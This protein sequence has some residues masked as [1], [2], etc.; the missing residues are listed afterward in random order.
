MAAI[1]GLVLP[2]G[3]ARL[4]VPAATVAEVAPEPAALKPL[5]ASE[6]WVAGYFHWRNYP[7][8]LISFE[9][10][11]ANL[12][13][14]GYSRVCVFHPLP[15]RQPHDYFALIVNGEPRTLEITD[16][17]TAAP[18]P[19][20]LSRRFVAG[21]IQVE[22]QT[23]VIPDFDALQAAFYPQGRQRAGSVPVQ[24]E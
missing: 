7:V 13:M 8:T 10:I 2:T 14:P 19:P 3:V 16:S 9:S 15:G 22:G 21:A 11:S 20:Q 5:P 23:L 24:G 4:V 6:R 18:P 1:P 17:A 12:G